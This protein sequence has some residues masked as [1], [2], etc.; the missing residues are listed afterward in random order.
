MLSVFKRTITGLLATALACGMAVSCGGLIYDDEGDC[1]IKVRFRYD[2]NMKFADAFPHEVERVT[3]YVL[4]ENGSI[5]WSK[6]DGGAALAAEDYS[7]EVDVPAGRYDLLAWCDS[8]DNGSFTVAKAAEKTG[9]KC[10][11]NLKSDTDG[12]SYADTD[13]DG[14]YHGFLSGADFT[15]GE[16]TVTVS[17]TKNTNYFNVVLQHIS[18]EPIDKERFAFSIVADNAFMDWDNS[19]ILQGDAGDRLDLSSC[20]GR[21]VVDYRAWSV[22]SGSAEVEK[23]VSSAAKASGSGSGLNVVVA[24][25]TTARLVGG[26]NDIHQPRLIVRNIATGDPVLSVPLIDFALL[27][28]GKYNA[29]MDDQEYLDRQ[30]QYNMIFF[31][32]DEDRWINSFIYINSWK[33]VLQDTDL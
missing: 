21:R 11:L 7:M 14:L 6:T 18:G 32:D 4:D 12:S 22:E 25:L 19:L 8:G 30:D 28:K 23:R 24:E 13:L 10:S 17:L 16:G 3:L 29:S 33:V 31:L 5:V 26:R 9:L 20:V 27:V 15:A 2:M 1:S